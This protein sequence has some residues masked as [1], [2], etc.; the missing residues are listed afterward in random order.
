MFQVATNQLNLPSFVRAIGTIRDII[1]IFDYMNR[2]E[3]HTAWTSS[4]SGIRSARS[5]FQDRYNR[6]VPQGSQ[7]LANLPEMWDEYIR[8]VLVP[9]IENNVGAWV[10]RRINILQVTWDEARAS[11]SGQRLDTILGILEGLAELKDG[12]RNAFIDTRDLD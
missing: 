5:H 9:Q 11:A 8:N 7:P 12:A 2:P 4:A 6:N 1:D 10:E 3:L